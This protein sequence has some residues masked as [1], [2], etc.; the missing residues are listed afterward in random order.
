M[1]EPRIA[2]LVAA[3]GRGTRAGLAYPKTL[4][5]VGGVPI[6]VRLLRGLAPI[7][8][9]PTVV[10]SPDGA[11]RIAEALAAAGRPAHLVVQ[12][13]PRGMGHAVLC[14]EQSSAFAAADE[15]LL[16][17]GDIP[18][19]QPAT[20]SELI[21]AHRR[22][23][24]DFS[25]VSRHVDAA[26]TVVARD[27]DGRVTGLVETREAGAIPAPGERDIGLFLFRKA[28]VFALLR[29]E[30]PG[31]YGARTGEH[32]FLY[33]VAH[34]AAR[35][36]RVEAFAIATEADLVSFNQ[37]ADLVGVERWL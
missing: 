36:L 26:Y 12:D 33:L 30:L 22:G 7:D 24:H 23:G 1:A 3:A 18:L 25:F 27:G 32:G 9:C 13:E 6:L 19:L 37:L 35:G 2:A 16:V 5:Q 29:E 8:P 14:F 28:P 11:P 10:A 4:Y 17:W 15:V 20:L 31:K 34:L 21:A